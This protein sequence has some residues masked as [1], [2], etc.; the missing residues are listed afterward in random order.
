MGTPAPDAVKRLVDRFDRDR[1]VFLSGDCKEEQLPRAKT[2]HEQESIRHLVVATD[3]KI[4]E[5]AY[6]VY[7]LTEDGIAVVEGRARGTEF[8]MT[9][10]IACGRSR[11]SGGV[12]SGGRGSRAL[13]QKHRLG[14]RGY[15]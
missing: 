8:K 2:P 14:M 3:R 11:A 10:R 15:K 6:E 4:D 7:G 1:K 12:L 5:L 9:R 13:H